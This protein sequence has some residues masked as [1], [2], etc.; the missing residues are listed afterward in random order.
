[1]R[2]VCQTNFDKVGRIGTNNVFCA[3]HQ[4]ERNGGEWG[5]MRI[6]IEIHFVPPAA[7]QRSVWF[8]LIPGYN[9]RFVAAIQFE[10]N[11]CLTRFS[12]G[13]STIRKPSIWGPFSVDEAFVCVRKNVRVNIFLLCFLNQSTE[14]ECWQSSSVQSWQLVF[15]NNFFDFFIKKHASCRWTVI[16]Y[17]F[18]CNLFFHY[19]NI[20]NKS[21]N[22]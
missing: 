18:W 13:A 14:S 15:L 11:T 16:F 7:N 2:S 5:M 12:R 10:G 17:I 20:I 21:S 9:T 19:V 8:A 6:P 1:M 4:I 22:F 3:T